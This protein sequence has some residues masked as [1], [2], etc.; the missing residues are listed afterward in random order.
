[1]I[2]KP[3]IENYIEIDEKVI[4][5]NELSQ[6]RREEMADTLHDKMMETARYQKVIK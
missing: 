2:K 6:K 4:L 5:I 1:M 3:V